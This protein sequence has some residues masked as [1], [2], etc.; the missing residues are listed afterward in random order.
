[1]AE[2]VPGATVV[3]LQLVRLGRVADVQLSCPEHGVPAPWGER[4]NEDMLELI[5]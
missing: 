2:Q 4:T 3:G 5:N 1:M